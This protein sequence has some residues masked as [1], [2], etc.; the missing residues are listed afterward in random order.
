VNIHTNAILFLPTQ[1]DLTFCF[2]N[3]ETNFEQNYT[4]LSLT[5]WLKKE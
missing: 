4:T 5:V 2:E 1:L 3:S